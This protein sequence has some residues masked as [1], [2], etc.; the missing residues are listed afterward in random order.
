VGASHTCHGSSV[1]LQ[2]T[3]VV[4]WHWGREKAQDDIIGVVVS[5]GSAIIRLWVCNMLKVFYRSRV[6]ASKTADF[7][8]AEVSDG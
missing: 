3:A 4:S 6:A 5:G 8:G 7:D 2:K 1:T